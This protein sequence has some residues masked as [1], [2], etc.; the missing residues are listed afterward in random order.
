MRHRLPTEKGCGASD[1]SDPFH[2]DPLPIATPLPCL[3]TLSTLLLCFCVA[4]TSLADSAPPETIPAQ[5]ATQAATQA[6]TQTHSVANAASPPSPRRPESLPVPP[7]TRT[8]SLPL[9]PLT[10]VR[11]LPEIPGKRKGIR[12]QA[13]CLPGPRYRILAVG[14]LLLHDRLQK[15]AQ[16]QGSFV[17]LWKSFAPQL[18]Q[19]D[20]SY[21]NLE[22]PAAAGVNAL[23]EN[24]RDPGPVFDRRVYNA[25]PFFNY[26]PRLLQDLAAS[27]FDVL[28]L[29]NNHILDRNALGID[30]TIDALER[31]GLAYTGARRSDHEITSRP[32]HARVTRNGLSTVWISCTYGTNGI[33]DYRHQVLHC[34][35]HQEVIKALVTEWRDQ[36]DAVL[37]TPHWGTEDS[38]IP[39]PEQG[40]FAKEMLELGALAV[41][42]SHPHTPQPMTK[43]RT[44]DGRETLIL[45]SLGNFVNGQS[46]LWQKTAMILLLDLVRHAGR[47]AIR[48]VHYLPGFMEQDSDGAAS[49]QPLDPDTPH[50][51][52]THLLKV[53]PRANMA[54]PATETVRD[55]HAPSCLSQAAAMDRPADPDVTPVTST[56]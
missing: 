37:I 32:W 39:R 51:G 25:F 35:Q 41:L 1:R 31:T 56:P 38:I 55:H 54:T 34:F 6:A 18:E 42:G 48:Q 23:G 2:Q 27:G 45:H 33:V 15:Q 17:P 44:R 4:R 16:R 43:H 5:D 36:V 22:G 28:S 53:L 24:V 11:A 3:R 10:T 26:P 49:L 19:A 21:V 8:R 46:R 20:V 13:E 29:G 30:R 50:P 40:R 52:L 14:D 47:V 7:S 9:Q 12:F